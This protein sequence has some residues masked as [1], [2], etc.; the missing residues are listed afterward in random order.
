[1]TA[2]PNA[3][4][5]APKP[6]VVPSE[7]KPKNSRFAVLPVKVDPATNAANIPTCTNNST[8]LEASQAAHQQT[9]QVSLVNSQQP[10]SQ[11]NTSF[12]ITSTNSVNAGVNEN[13][14]AVQSRGPDQRVWLI[15]ILKL[16]N[17]IGFRKLVPLRIITSTHTT[18]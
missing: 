17:F 10:I 16:V 15:D 9:P 1:M 7:T 2:T 5:A 4:N 13:N 14:L 12:D 11:Q 6:N 3:S 18:T 8:E